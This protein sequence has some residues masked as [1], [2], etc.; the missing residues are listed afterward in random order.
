MAPAA[1]CRR[2]PDLRLRLRD[3]RAERAA[4]ES[5]AIWLCQFTPSVSLE[6]PCSVLAEI[7]GSLRL[8]GGAA[9]LIGRL[10]RGLAG[11]GFEASL[12][13]APTARAALWTA[14]S[15]A[16]T[17]QQLPLET[18]GLEP[19]ELEAL[20][21]FGVRTLG[22]LLAL[23]RAGLARR[24]GPAPLARLDQ[25]LGMAPEPRLWFAPPERFSA[26]LEL[27]VE[28]QESE[29]LQF[30]AHQLLKRLEGFLAARHAAVRRCTLVLE[31][32]RADALEIGIHLA[33]PA[34]DAGR[35]MRVLRERLAAV[36]LCAPVRAIRL[37][38]TD[39]AGHAGSTTDLFRDPRLGGE[40]WLQLLERLRAR[41]GETAA[42]G[43]EI[44]P[45][46]R[47]EH[48][49]RSVEPGIARGGVPAG[50]GSRPLWLLDP[51]RR[52]RVAADVP[53]HHGPLLL[54][55]GPERIQSGWWDGLT[56][57]RDYFIARAGN[58]SLTWIYRSSDG[59]FLHG[60]FA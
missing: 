3:L 13:V 48:A 9:R 15:G 16:P 1:A 10:R 30:A 47:P 32:G 46:N 4:L 56:V 27:P 37:E 52:L 51:P 60:I 5:I 34:R 38:A 22:E 7:A 59:W 21:D 50:Q 6:P 14:R 18:M 29:M 55:A 53:Q 39:L 45:E 40:Q 42:H 17:L 49:W 57:A 24:I 33:A 31:Q 11:L 28:V 58:A 44:R 2:V 54:L 26:R 25:A 36:H 35:M 41:L 8:H 12:A 20:R 19:G 43:L 23:P